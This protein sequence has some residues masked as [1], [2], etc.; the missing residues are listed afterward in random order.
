MYQD[1][2]QVQNRIDK[3][4]EKFKEENNLDIKITFVEA[5]IISI[6]EGDVVVVKTQIS[7]PEEVLRTMGKQITEY[8]PNNKCIVLDSNLSLDVV[9]KEEM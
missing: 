8:F 5:S 3:S 7:L 2:I 9:R 6:K 1:E 4:L